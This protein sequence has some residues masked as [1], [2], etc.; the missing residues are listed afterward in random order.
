MNGNI[1]LRPTKYGVPTV[2]KHMYLNNAAFTKGNTAPTQVIL[3]DLNAWK[4]DIG[5]DAVMTRMLRSDW[6]IGTDLIVKVCWYID[7]V[8]ASDKEIQWRVRW[9]ALPHDFS[10]TVDAPVHSGEIDSGDIDIPAI[11]KRMGVSIIG[12]I[13]GTSL[14]VKD[15]LGFTLSRIAV[16]HDNPTQDPAAHHL[17]IDYTADKLGD[18][19]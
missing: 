8:Y 15:M 13:P 17:V 14:S 7:E 1:L 2:T 19:T 9:T 6:K 3:G 10:E 5:D 11:A 16:T 4:F 18:A 12:T